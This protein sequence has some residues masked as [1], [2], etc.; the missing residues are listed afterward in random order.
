MPNRETVVALLSKTTNIGFHL[1]VSHV[2]HSAVAPL[3]LYSY[4]PYPS[5]V[6]HAAAAAATLPSLVLS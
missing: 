5:I 6:I 1:S 3:L 2:I 4:T